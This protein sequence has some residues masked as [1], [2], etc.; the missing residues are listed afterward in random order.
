MKNNIV[1]S[2][3]ILF[4]VT[5]LALMIVV[6]FNNGH[7][8]MMI[9]ILLLTMLTFIRDFLR[10]QYSMNLSGDIFSDSFL[11]ISAVSTN[12]EISN[13]IQLLIY[14]ICIFFISLIVKLIKN[15]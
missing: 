7:I 5:N 12:L 14:S 2:V 3:V 10:N 9:S 13:I 1:F 8:A 11:K 4:F 15:N 6:I